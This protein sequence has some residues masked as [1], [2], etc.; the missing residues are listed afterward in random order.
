[1]PAYR[2]HL[3]FPMIWENGKSYCPHREQKLFPHTC[4]IL[5]T[6]L[7]LESVAWRLYKFQTMMWCVTRLA[8]V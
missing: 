2:R 7:A 5:Q 1:M 6:E 8:W 4:R 3:A